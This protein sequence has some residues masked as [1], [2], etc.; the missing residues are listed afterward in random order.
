MG[1]NLEQGENLVPTTCSW[2]CRG[3]VGSK[4]EMTWGEVF[5]IPR[6]HWVRRTKPENYGD[7]VLNREVGVR[8]NLK[9]GRMSKRA[10]DSDGTTTQHQI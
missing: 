3:L 8:A 2:S 4:E 1:W 6:D 9:E 7:R 10:R 5:G